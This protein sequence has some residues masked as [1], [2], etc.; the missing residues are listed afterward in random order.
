M[1]RNILGR[2]M[3]VLLI[4]LLASLW[5]PQGSWAAP[6][7]LLSSAKGNLEND[8]LYYITVDR[9]YDGDERNNVPTFAF[10]KISSFDR[11]SDPKQRAYNQVN[12]SLIR[13]AYDPSHRYVGM[14]WGGDLEGVIQKLDYL[15]D[16]GVTQLVLSPIQDNANALLYSPGG[17]NI[18]RSQVDPQA[19]KQDPFYSGLYTS[20]HGTW[21]KDWFEI[22]EHLR[23]P[24]AEQG[25]HLQVLRRLLDQAG[26]RG[27]GVIL[28]LNLNGTSPYR[29]S[30]EYGDF[31][32]DRGEQWIIDN[33]A[34]YRQGEQVASYLD[35]GSAQQD[36]QGWFHPSLGID[37]KHPTQ[38]M[39]EKGS[40][41]GL[42][43]LAQEREQ[44]R[45]Y[46][47]DAI[48][49]WLTLNPEGHQI[50]G[51][52]LEPIVNIPRQFWQDLEERVASIDP[53]AILIGEYSGA[54]YTNREAV[55]WY[56]QTQDY[57][58]VDYD[59]SMA[60]RNYFRRVRNWAGRTYML[61]EHAL[62]HAGQYYNYS[63][64]ELILHQ[65]LNPSESLEIPRL[66][67]DLIPDRDARGWI[68]FIESHD[69]P[70]LFSND[71]NMTKQAYRSLIA[72]T[73]VSPGVPMLMYGV[74]TGLAVPYHIDQQ[75]L[76][77]VGGSPFNLPMMIWPEDAGWD[78]DL[79][80]ITRRL[81]G[82]RQEIPVLRYG[83]TQFLTPAGS[84]QDNDLFM[85]R[86]DPDCD[87]TQDSCSQVLFA[88]STFGGKFEIPLSSAQVKRV[89]GGE[90]DREIEVDQGILG[91]E[92]QPEAA[93]VFVIQP[94]TEA[95]AL[96]ARNP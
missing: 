33:G 60:A 22:D 83:E 35:P 89:L 1:N 86:L 28:E 48:Q 45:D 17:G 94:K 21:T 16:L 34:V 50:S 53:N 39:L 8:V 10:P 57:T 11:S 27:I 43:D 81:I 74:E 40:V 42:P 49:F 52:Y 91:I 29:G 66:S 47:L 20:F 4:G 76:F 77:G 3:I 73:L 72:F 96:L 59:N 24:E 14:Y 38:A 2:V 19:E 93:Q 92:L 87:G 25:D 5:Y 7:L 69:Q 32:L 62:G 78:R 26:E 64:P 88:Y 54:G 65:V 67:L 44:V 12:R 70:R 71:P 6:D 36:P 46:L 75:G 79:F 61:R 90:P 23:D 30:L 37:Y 55:N 9:F 84:R 85:I 58:W 56:A 18:I 82:L 31:S 68:N 41:G 95:E 15:Q 51:F 63:T 80:E 13:H